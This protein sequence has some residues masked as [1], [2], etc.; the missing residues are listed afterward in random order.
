[1][2]SDRLAGWSRP[3]GFDPATPSDEGDRRWFWGL[4]LVLLSVEAL[5]RR[6]Q[7][8]MKREISEPE[9]RVA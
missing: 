9:A 7:S 6:S 5:L 1:M 2:S 8:D 4:A 3:V